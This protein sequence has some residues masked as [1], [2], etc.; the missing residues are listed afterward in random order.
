MLTPQDVAQVANICHNV[1]LH[2]Q[3]I[4]GSNVDKLLEG[5]LVF[6]GLFNLTN[7]VALILHIRWHKN[8][9]EI[10]SRPG[11]RPRGIVA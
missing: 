1:A 11:V 2:T 4:R 6:G 10:E 8:E 7:G 5:L 3:S 9:R